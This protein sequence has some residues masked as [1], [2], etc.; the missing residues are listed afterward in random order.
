MP[1]GSLP[2]L[3][4]AVDGYGQS[5][6][7][8]ALLLERANRTLG[9]SGAVCRLGQI[10]GPVE[11]RKGWWNRHEW[12][13]TVIAASR[14]LG[15]LPSDLAALGTIDWIPVDLTAKILIELAFADSD[16]NGGEN[17][18]LDYPLHTAAGM[19]TFHVVNT[20]VCHWQDLLPAVR[21]HLGGAVRVVP[22]RD[23]VAAL[24]REA[25]DGADDINP[26]AKLVDFFRG[27]LRSMDAGRE[28][29]RL[30][31]RMTERHTKTLRELGPV[32]EEW[33]RIWL[34]QWDF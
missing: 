13:P 19:R 7:V 20:K 15:L 14:R 12:L 32:T 17:D 8:A 26:G 9:V 22:F 18:E 6:A 21:D 4:L 3:T 31:T 2:D 5:K 30:D 23:W 11:R 29:T 34:K 24:D 27:L 33:M 1:E 16:E 28:Y 10:A 25:C